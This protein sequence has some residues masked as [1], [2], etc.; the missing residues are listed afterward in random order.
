MNLKICL[1]CNKEFEAKESR[2]KFCC[3]K[4]FSKYQHNLAYQEYLN[5]SDNYCR[6]NYTPKAFKNDFLK[7]QGNK[8]A[9]CG[10]SPE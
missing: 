2:S 9:I 1:G 3:S 7:E 8:C 4:C 6:G 5:N 10:I